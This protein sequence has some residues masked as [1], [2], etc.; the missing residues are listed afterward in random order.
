MKKP[1]AIWLFAGGP[2]Q[3]SAA[4]SIVAL[5]HRLIV[6]DLNPQCVCARYADEF[7]AFDTFDVDS[8][9][10]AA[11]D[12]TEKY[13]IR[14]VVTLA[15][16]CHHTVAVISQHLGL[17]GISPD[18]SRACRQKNL[19]REILTAA[20]IP[21][22]RFKCV[23]TLAEAQAFLAELGGHGVIKATDNSASRGFAKL[24]AV[25]EL[26][27]EVFQAAVAAGTTGVALVEEALVPRH[28]CISELSVETVWFEG[29]MY[30]LNWVDRLFAPDLK[31]FP[32][33]A[34]YQD[35]KINWGVEVG[36]INPAQHPLAVKEQV[37]ALVKA[38]GLALGMGKEAG[39]HVLKA[40]IMLTDAGPMI[41]EMTP[42]LSGGWDS[43]A[44]TPA[45]G[46]DFQ[47]GI[48]Q[49]A[50]GEPLDLGLWHRH[51]EFK[52]PNLYAAI[53]ANISPDA[54]DC[55]GR[56]FALGTDF[57]RERSLQLSLSNLKENKHVL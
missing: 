37:H 5:G 30:W 51:F 46:A 38:A 29:E 1:Q 32:T 20:G 9:L 48:I 27:D 4:K 56:Q 13:E 36:H 6:T 22:P 10:A 43:S 26:T 44:T 55:V 16:D 49:L 34:R 53:L 7:L 54:K 57:G 15:A 42:R 19:T 45:R 40:D 33:L 28:D 8:N 17:H 31:F 23:R 11:R 21:Q 35:E 12:L 24:N 50:L 18:I 52:N 41:I 25:S 47:G 3:E 2:M 39:G 14:A